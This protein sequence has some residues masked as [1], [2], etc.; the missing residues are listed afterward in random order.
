M[1][2]AALFGLL[3]LRYGAVGGDQTHSVAGDHWIGLGFHVSCAGILRQRHAI[4]EAR[5]SQPMR[6]R[7]SLRSPM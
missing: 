4:G 5:E 6:T 3:M 2:V 7:L 1:G